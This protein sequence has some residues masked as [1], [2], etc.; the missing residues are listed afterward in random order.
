MF[1]RAF[2]QS[3]P[4]NILKQIRDRFPTTVGLVMPLSKTNQNKTKTWNI[5]ALVTDTSQEDMPKLSIEN[6]QYKTVDI[7]D[8]DLDTLKTDNPTAYILTKN[9]Q[10]KVQVEI[11]GETFKIREEK[12][13]QGFEKMKRFLCERSTMTS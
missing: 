10:T 9:F 13:P 8:E 6:M 2:L 1:S 4:M 12:N 3:R 5:V 7:F 11:N